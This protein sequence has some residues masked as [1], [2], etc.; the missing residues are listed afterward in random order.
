M[1]N[2]IHMHTYIHTYAHLHT[3]AP[4]PKHA[5]LFLR[6]TPSFHHYTTRHP[7]VLLCLTPLPL[8]PPYPPP[9]S[10]SSPP[11]PPPLLILFFSLTRIL[12]RSNLPRLSPSKS[13][14]QIRACINT[15]TR[16]YL[17]AL[18]NTHNIYTH[19]SIYTYCIYIHKIR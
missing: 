15:Y 14:Y 10:S 19:R 13:K 7:Y 8:P 9:L 2:Y 6:P 1:P 11:P 18:Y 5:R 17:Q 16:D 3:H 4:D 12:Y